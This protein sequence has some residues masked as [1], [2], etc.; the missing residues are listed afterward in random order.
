MS[1]KRYVATKD[2]TITNAYKDGLKARAT[3]ANMGAS[4]SLEL[5]S[6]YGR[7]SEFESEKSRILI[8]FPIEPIQRDRNEFSIGNS[9]SC[10]FILKLSN[11]AHKESVPSKFTLSVNPISGSWDEGIGLDM[12]SYKDKDFVN[13]I[14]RSH[15][16]KW[17][18]EGGDFYS[19][20]QFDK[21]FEN[22]VEDLEIDITYLVEQW[23]EGTL[24]NNGLLIR[25]SDSIEDGTL[26]YYTK[27]FSSRTSEYFFKVPWI[28]CR[29]D[30]SIKDDRANFYTYNKFV[31]LEENYNTI[32]MYNRFKGKLYDFP[33]IGTGS[34]YVA[35]YKSIT[36]PLP[37]PLI[38]ITGSTQSPVSILYSVGTHV[39]TGIYKCDV[40]VNT[41]EKLIYDVWYNEDRTFAAV[42]G[43]IYPRDPEGETGNVEEQFLYNIKNLKSRYS[44][45]DQAT[46]QVFSRNVGWNPNS[47]TSI[48]SQNNLNFPDNLYYKVFRIVDNYEV[49]PYGT[50]S[51]NHTR[52]S[53]DKD[54]CYFDLDMSLFE[55]GYS[56]GIKF[57]S[58]DRNKYVESKEEFKFRVE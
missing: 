6:L 40:C 3:D 44:T 48:Q 41:D 49:I 27:K 24:P 38:Q 34:I 28:E 30:S 7:A 47:Y 54:G 11:V 36:T 17:T 2:T 10:Q 25:M 43:T 56:Y 21:Y 42:G 55:P 46:F 15:D 33:E 50:G 53:T 29:T 39:S 8:Y 12:E 4:D 19:F 37:T 9:G 45:K 1:I 13:W 16:K 20:P 32:Y 51:Y 22:G 57:I 23:L 18:K 52:L 14:Y 5:F 58:V 26:N 35:L 31:S